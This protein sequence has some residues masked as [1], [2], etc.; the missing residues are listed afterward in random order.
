MLEREA[1]LGEARD[2][3]QTLDERREPRQLREGVARRGGEPPAG[4]VVLRA[5]LERAR[6]AV[7]LEAQRRDGRAQLVRRDREEL[8]AHAHGLQEVELEILAI[9][10]VD[11]RADVARE[12]AV[13]L[14]ARR[15]AIEHPAVL[16]VGASQAVLH[17]EGPALGEGRHVRIDARLE[18]LEVHALGPAHAP[19]LLERAARELEPGLVEERAERVRAR[20]PEQHGRDVG[21]DAE[22]RLGL[23]RAALGPQASGRVAQEADASLDGAVGGAPRQVARLVGARCARLGAHGVG[24]GGAVRAV[25]EVHR[26]AREHAAQGLRPPG[27]ERPRELRRHGLADGGRGAELEHALHRGVPVGAHERAIEDDHA[28]AARGED[29][30]GQLAGVHGAPPSG[31]ISRARR[32]AAARSPTAVASKATPAADASMGASASSARSASGTQART[33]AAATDRL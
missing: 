31:S 8:V 10:D 5:P 29:E 14:P 23:A 7:E 16:A 17:L 2:V 3:Q 24:V 4:E 9:G 15:A 1:T 32:N 6:H 12:A 27:A 25:V 21:H 30:L 20:H 28:V 19:L 22:A 18:V 33:Q 13:G 11:A 26:L